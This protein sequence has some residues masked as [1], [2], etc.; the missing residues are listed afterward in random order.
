MPYRCLDR[1]CFKHFSVRTN[2]AVECSPIPLRK[3]LF[4]MY[5]MTSARKGIS[6]VQLAKQLRVTQKTAWFMEHRI[7]ESFASPEGL[8]GAGGGIVEVDETYLGGK[9]KN[10][11]WN[12]RI[13]FG[14]GSVG[15]RLW[16]ASAIAVRARS[17]PRWSITST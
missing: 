12:K 13:R 17:R 3:W 1:S 4:A 15:R 5:L 16:S 9:E 2:S 11:H 14:R 6:S 7:R 8:L 10:K